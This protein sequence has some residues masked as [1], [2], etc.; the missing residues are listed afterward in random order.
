VKEWPV[1]FNSNSAIKKIGKINRLASMCLV[2]HFV[3]VR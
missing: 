1:V 2:R 3:N